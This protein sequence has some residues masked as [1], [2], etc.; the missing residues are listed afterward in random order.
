MQ[1]IYTN[2]PGRPTHWPA[3]KLQPLHGKRTGTG[4]L[5][6]FVNYL[7]QITLSFTMF[8]NIMIN[9]SRTQASSKRIA[10][11]F[12]ATATVREPDQPASVRDWDIEFKNVSFRYNAGGDDVLKDISFSIQQ[13]ETVSIIFTFMVHSS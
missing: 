3:C 4:K 13:E 7:V 1:H 9:L 12:A 2:T 5:V 8:V 6:A 11:V 10:E